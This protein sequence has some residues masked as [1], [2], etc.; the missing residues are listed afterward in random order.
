MHRKFIQFYNNLGGFGIDFAHNKDVV[1][2]GLEKVSKGLLKYGVTSYCPTL[3]TSDPEI[4]H[5]ILPKITKTSG[6]KSGA[7]ILGVHVEG[8]FISVL[9]KGAHKAE[10]IRELSNVIKKFQ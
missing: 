1:E 7:N 8:P 3:V 10:S 9:K 4:Y 6:G 2:N 5:Q